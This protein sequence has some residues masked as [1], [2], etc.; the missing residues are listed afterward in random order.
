M[1]TVPH[2]QYAHSTHKQYVQSTSQTAW[3]QYYRD[4]MNRVFQRLHEHSTSQWAWVLE[5]SWT[6]YSRDI[7]DTVF[8]IY[9][10]QIT[11]ESAW[12][13]YF[14]DSMNKVPSRLASSFLWIRSDSSSCLLTS[15]QDLS[16]SSG[17]ETSGDGQWRQQSNPVMQSIHL[18]VHPL[19]T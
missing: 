10:E 4:S 19:I 17:T 2:R 13:Q 6:Q 9:Q 3:T 18:S 11:S 8:Q 12:T 14:K 7:L 15:W 16:S 1:H 5:I